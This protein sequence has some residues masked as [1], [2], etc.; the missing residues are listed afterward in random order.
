MMLP[1]QFNNR[2]A[3]RSCNRPVKPSGKPVKNVVELVVDYSVPNI[4]DY[5]VEIRRMRGSE[6]LKVIG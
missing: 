4:A 3:L 1:L 5:V 6:V 2:V